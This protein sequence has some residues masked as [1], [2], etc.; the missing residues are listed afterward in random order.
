MCVSDRLQQLDSSA[1]K[2][3][4]VT[5]WSPFNLLLLYRSASRSGG[6]SEQPLPV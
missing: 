6:A 3:K 5:V 4:S 1:K 2:V